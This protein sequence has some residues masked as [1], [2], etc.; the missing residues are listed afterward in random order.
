M[1]SFS[2]K[3]IC[4]HLWNRPHRP[5]QAKPISADHKICYFARHVQLPSFF[6]RDQAVRRSTPYGRGRPMCGPFATCRVPDF[7]GVHS[8]SV[9]QL[10]S[11]AQISAG[12]GRIIDVGH[13]RRCGFDLQKTK[14]NHILNCFFRRA[15]LS[16]NVQFQAMGEPKCFRRDGTTRNSICVPADIRSS[17]P[18]SKDSIYFIVA[19]DGAILPDAKSI[20]S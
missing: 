4:N 16:N 15:A 19:S 9:Q 18:Y 13:F 5:R 10:V 2:L 11:I 1:G 17:R 8:L 7:A 14:I 12:A 20:T 3:Y 6:R